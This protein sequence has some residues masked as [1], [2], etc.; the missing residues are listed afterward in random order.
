MLSFNTK[1]TLKRLLL[2]GEKCRKIRHYYLYTNAFER[3]LFL[4]QTRKKSDRKEESLCALLL[5]PRSPSALCF[6]VSAVCPPRSALC[7]CPSLLE[8]L[9]LSALLC[10]P[11]LS[12]TLFVFL[13]LS[14]LALSLALSPSASLSLLLCFVCFSVYLFLSLCVPHSFPFSIVSLSLSLSLAS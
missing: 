14:V 1:R 11:S 9:S 4:R 5:I 13:S 8:S 2:G 12:L 3:R 7:S 10:A 6:L